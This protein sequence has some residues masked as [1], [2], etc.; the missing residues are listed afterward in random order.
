MKSG[1]KYLTIRKFSEL[2][3]TT[4][5]TLKH[6]DEIGLLTPAYIGENKYRYYLPEQSLILTRILFGKH[7]GIPLKEIRS[8]IHSGHHTDAIQKYN[9]IINDLRARGKET[10]AIVSTID[11]LRYYYSLSEKHPPRTLFSLYLPEWFILFSEKSKIDAAHESSSSDIANNLFLEGFNGQKW[12]HYLLG[13]LLPEENI[14]TRNFSETKYFLKI[15]TPQLYDKAKI[16][17]VPN[18]EIGR[19]SCRE[20]V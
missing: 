6:Y 9:E 14:K 15:D 3:H 13:A 11:N 2:T 20:R 1:R 8:F 5:D 16:R 7:A 17:F 4:V 18:G 10:E 12:P 19:A